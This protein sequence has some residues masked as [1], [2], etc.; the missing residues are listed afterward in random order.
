MEHERH[1]FI[2]DV[3][4]VSFLVFVLDRLVQLHIEDH[5]LNVVPTVKVF[6][7]E[8]L[9]FLVAHDRTQVLE[10]IVR[11]QYHLSSGLALT[12]LRILH[13]GK[14]SDSMSLFL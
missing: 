8:L 11:A 7:I 4:L 9:E 1:Q 5:A 13:F 2:A 14:H 10:K 12:D 6:V 3:A